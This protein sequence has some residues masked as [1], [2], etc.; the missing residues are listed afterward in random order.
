L[1]GSRN[2]FAAASCIHVL[3]H[4]P[5]ADIFLDQLTSLTRPGAPIYIE[6]PLQL[7]GILELLTRARGK[8]GR[9]SIN[10][11]HHHYFF[12]PTALVRLLNSHGI[13]VLSLTTFQR[14]RRVRRRGA[15]R[16]VGLQLLLWTA[17]RIARR[18][19]VISLWARRAA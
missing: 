5:N 8:A 2:L 4:V 1:L 18:G 15:V 9:Y 19:D 14:C 3:E 6:V 16:R 13:D 17:D 12:T 7:D 11:I 10:S